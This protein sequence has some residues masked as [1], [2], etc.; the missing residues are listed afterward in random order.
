MR[1]TAC[2]AVH[3]CMPTE[4]HEL[5]HI[6]RCATVLGDAID[7]EVEPRINFY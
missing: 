6:K 3:A 2:A 7:D 4:V 5:W 1:I